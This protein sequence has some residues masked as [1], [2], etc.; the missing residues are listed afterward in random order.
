MKRIGMIGGMGPLATAD[1]FLKIIQAT[2]AQCDQEHIPLIIDNYPQIEDRTRAILGQ[3]TSPLPKLIESAQ[4]LKQA[5]CE[6]ICMACNTAHY[7]AHDIQAA[8]DIKLLHIA[9]IAAEAI[10]THYPKVK[11]IALLAT[12]GTL[13]AKI[14]HQPLRDRGYCIHL[15]SSDQQA[16]LMQCIYQGAKA[17]HVE[18]FVDTFQTII[19]AMRVDLFIA[20]CTE[21]PLFLPH[22]HSDTP[23]ID[24][25]QA[26]ADAVVR[27]SL[28]QG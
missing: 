25:T 3:G 28:A 20:G 10:G 19:D 13:H 23:F 21:I 11:H 6:A 27:Y 2:H 5:G 9:N 12:D 16:Q 7:F 8:V 14:Y 17:G 26:L 1:L 24:P 15:P 4:R 22:I 18:A